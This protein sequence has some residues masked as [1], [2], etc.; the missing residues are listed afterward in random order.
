M[1][2]SQEAELGAGEGGD[3]PG[4]SA[5]SAEMGGGPQLGSGFFSLVGI[6]FLSRTS[7]LTW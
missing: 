1:R 6:L 5:I 2:N 4:A 3:A 7:K